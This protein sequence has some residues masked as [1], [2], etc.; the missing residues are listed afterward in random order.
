MDLIEGSDLARQPCPGE[1]ESQRWV[2]EVAEAI[3]YAHRAGVV[4]CD[5]KPSNLLLGRDGHVVVTDFGLARSLAGGDAPH[6]GTTGFMAPEQSDPDGRVSPRTDVYG[7]GA[8]LQALL[9]ERSPEVDALCR[10]CQAKE[11][12]GRY[13]SAAE[14]ASILRRLLAAQL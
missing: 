12:E 1:V 4:H 14:V 8:V 7:L 5:L 10:R 3:E 6:G 13:A 11:P 9:P 2:A